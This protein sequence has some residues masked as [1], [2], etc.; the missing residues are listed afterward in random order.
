MKY[1]TKSVKP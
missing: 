1:G